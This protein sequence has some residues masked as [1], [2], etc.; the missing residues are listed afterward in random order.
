MNVGLNNAGK[1]RR[2]RREHVT[3]GKTSEQE[4]SS[5]NS[6]AGKGRKP[7]IQRQSCG[8]DTQKE[9]KSKQRG[10]IGQKMR[11]KSKGVG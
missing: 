11:V 6:Q 8:M 9:G 3:L 7:S 2:E 5:L 1:D 4:K 10:R